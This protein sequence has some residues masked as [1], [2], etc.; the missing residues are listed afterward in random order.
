MIEKF[1][2][3]AHKPAD[4]VNLRAFFPLYGKRIMPE[5]NPKDYPIL[6]P[7]EWYLL[8]N[9]V[10]DLCEQSGWKNVSEALQYVVRQKQLAR[11]Q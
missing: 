3:L 10:R 7:E 6:T 9:R 2:L 1:T 8:V 11:N 5:P 4:L